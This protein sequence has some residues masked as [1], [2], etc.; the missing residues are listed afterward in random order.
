M[1]SES[2][3]RQ[4]GAA[5]GSGPKSESGT[6]STQLDLIPPSSVSSGIY[7]VP[8]ERGGA[9]WARIGHRPRMREY[10]LLT[11]VRTG[12]GGHG[13]AVAAWATITGY[14]SLVDERSLA[15]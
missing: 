9:E 5:S 1:G 12:N 14:S 7:T 10:L 4:V 3:L 13:E 2:V 15:G 11:H 6:R 8:Q